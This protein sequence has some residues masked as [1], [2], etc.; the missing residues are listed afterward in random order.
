MGILALV[1]P[2]SQVDENSRDSRGTKNGK[3]DPYTDS[4]EGHMASFEE[5]SRHSRE[6]DKLFVYFWADCI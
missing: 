6:T 1:F 4:Y 2:A 5:T 3:R